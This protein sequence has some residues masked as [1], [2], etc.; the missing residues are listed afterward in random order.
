M[1][2][3]R[4]PSAIDF[5]ILM[6]FF[7]SVWHSLYPIPLLISVLFVHEASVSNRSLLNRIF[8][9]PLILAKRSL[10]ASSAELLES[11]KVLWAGARSTTRGRKY[12]ER[13]GEKPRASYP[14]LQYVLETLQCRQKRKCVYS[15]SP[16]S[17]ALGHMTPAYALM[18]KI[19][20]FLNGQSAF[21]LIFV[22]SCKSA[23]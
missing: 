11:S 2:G 7:L 23:V 6:V 21:Y 14:H 22:R 9:V 19:F 12:G 8:P 1:S 17:S 4:H 20:C 13:A 16:S 10:P 5:F 15:I 3:H 18:A